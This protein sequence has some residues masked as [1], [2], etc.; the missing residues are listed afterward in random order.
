M[1]LGGCAREASQ[2]PMSS[3]D[4]N[5]Q[6]KVDFN[7]KGELFYNVMFNGEVILLNAQLGLTMA[8]EDFSSGLSLVNTSDVTTVSDTYQLKT[9]KRASYNYTFN[10][11]TLLV[12]NPNDAQMEVVF[13]LADNGFAFRYRFPD[14]SDEVK[15][16]LSEASSFRFTEGTLG[17]LSPMSVAKT[18]WEATNPSYEENYEV[19]VIPG[20]PSPLGAGWVYPA[21]FNVGEIWMLISEADVDRNYCGTRLVPGNN[22]LEYK[23]GFPDERE[24]FTDSHVNPRFTLPMQ[25]PWRFMAVGSLGDVVE[26][27][28]GTDLAAPALDMDFSWVQPGIA[29]WSWIILKDESVNYDT[30]IEYIDF[31]SEMGWAYCLV[32]ASWD[33][34]IGYARIAQLSKYAQTKGVELILWY[35]SAGDWNTTPYT[36][37]HKM[38]TRESREAEFALLNDMGIKGVKVDFFGGDGQPM[39][40]YY[41]D[42]FEDA[43]RYG[44]MVNCHGTTLPRGWHRTYPNFVTTEAVKGME[45][46]TFV[47]ENADQAPFHNVMQVFT[48]N[49]FDPM[50]YT[51]MN[52]SGLPGIERRTTV[53]HELALPVLFTSGVQHLAETPWG[54]KEMPDYIQTFL[55]ELPTAWTE[56][57]FVDGFPGKYAVVARKADN[58]W[59]V[60]GING[61]NGPKVLNLDLSFTGMD[62]SGYL[63]VDGPSVGTFDRKEITGTM[64][65][66]TLQANG[67]FVAFFPAL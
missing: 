42:L 39:M 26:S 60:A 62:L 53:A 40:A 63:L 41:H 59:Y 61:E 66:V 67:G 56:T 14:A 6:V 33:Q 21:L 32:D 24:T 54:M 4:G 16:I 15:E 64:L 29:S 12:V 17:Y 11:Q 18:G 20:T 45:F 50:D 37:K 35:N 19:E 25:T 28:L 13:R 22:A 8:D 47:Q 44:I 65:E 58:G 27:S 38:L 10:E 7:D 30:T 57:Q 31:A 55:K 36:P 9:G 2:Q 3:P 34:R 49:V 23:I 46:I 43:A 51:P 5:L 48:R 52:L 1:V